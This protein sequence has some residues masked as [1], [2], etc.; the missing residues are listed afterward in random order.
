MKTSQLTTDKNQLLDS[1]GFMNRVYLWML[2]GMLITS[3]S[4]YLSQ[5]L[6]V[7]MLIKIN[8]GLMPVEYF[9]YVIGLAII[10]QLIAVIVLSIFIKKM[11]VKVAIFLY[12]LYTA[13]VGLSCATIFFIYAKSDIVNAFLITAIAFSGLSAYGYYTKRDLSFLGTFCTMGLFGVVGFMILGF[14]KP[15]IMTDRVQLI[16]A[17]VAIIVFSGL[18]AF[19]TKKIKALALTMSDETQESKEAIFGAL[20][21][22]LDFINLFLAILRLKKH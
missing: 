12:C 8:L 17:C 1:V 18:T 3:V 7:D 6:L 10:S 16:T 4:A 21:L 13:L 9:K 11:S 22:Y 15:T 5:Q 20:I 19:D 2:F 14:L